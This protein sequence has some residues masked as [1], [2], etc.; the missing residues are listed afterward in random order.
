MYKGIPKINQELKIIKN[1][2][3]NANFGNILAVVGSNGF[4]VYGRSPCPTP[5]PFKI[6]FLRT[7]AFVKLRVQ[8][9]RY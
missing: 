4:I 3:T 1:M 5:T 8:S 7:E 9:G 2:T 6:Q